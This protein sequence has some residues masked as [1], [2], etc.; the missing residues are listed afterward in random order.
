M[1][2]NK[3]LIAILAGLI[4]VGGLAVALGAS[5]SGPGDVDNGRAA[6]LIADGVRIVDVRTAA[7]FSMGHIPGAENVPVN[8]LSS[9][10]ASWDKSAPVLVYCAVGDRSAGAMQ[11]LVSAGFTNVYNLSAGIAAWDGDIVTGTEV[12]EAPA[13]DPAASGL[14][15]LYEFYTDW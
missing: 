14:P 2:R 7:E 10:I 9:A 1:L 4:V 13:A 8:E 11:T 6:E 5:S 12:A 15:V 3:A